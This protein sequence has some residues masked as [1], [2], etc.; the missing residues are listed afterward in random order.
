LE[1]ESILVVSLLFN[2]GEIGGERVFKM[3]RGLANHFDVN[4][5][6]SDNGESKTNLDFISKSF[7]FKNWYPR[8]LTKN[9]KGFFD[10]F[11][12]K[13]AL[14]I[15][16]ILSR[17]TPYDRAIFDKKNLQKKLK[18]IIE[19]ELPKA[20][21]VSLAP[22]SLARYVHE[23]VK[24][25]DIKLIVDL[26]DP[27]TWAEAYGMSI[28]SKNRLEIEKKREA[29]LIAFAHYILVPTDV[30]KAHLVAKY[31]EFRSRFICIPHSVDL[32]DLD[33]IQIKDFT[34]RKGIVFGG[35]IYRETE[36]ILSRALD[37]IDKNEATLSIYS[38]QSE[39]WAGYD[40]SEKYS[41]YNSLKRNDFFKVLNDSASFL[42]I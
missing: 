31:P 2:N 26:R 7:I 40:Y 14:S 8:I 24:G 15:I 18:L 42:A 17:G 3:A 21:I 33:K 34:Q 38:N 23:I 22:F 25:L 4:I 29:D 35:T 41:F 10:K 12:Y 32:H 20:I 1:K 27:Y 9:L 19:A 28:I 16:S 13:I 11:H 5:L 39:L 6:T 36:S 37:V 30:M